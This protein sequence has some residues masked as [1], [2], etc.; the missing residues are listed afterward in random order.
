M[1]DYEKQALDFLKD[2]NA[3]MKIEYE[4]DIDGFPF[5][6]KDTLPHRKYNVTLSC[7]DKQYKF[8]FYGSYIDWVQK[9]DP[10]EY[11]ILAWLMTYDVGEMAD[12]VDDFGYVIK[13]RKSFL[14]AEKAWESCKEQYNTLKS[15]FSEEMFERLQEI[16]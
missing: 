4:K 15:M 14:R 9:K 12:F 3:E 1:T 5:D 10:D 11:S 16:S 6:D 7:N 8:P 13:D 2:A